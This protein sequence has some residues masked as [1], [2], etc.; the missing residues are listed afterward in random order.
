MKALVLSGGGCR[1]AFQVGVLKKMLKENPELDYDIYSGISVGALNTSMLASG[2]LKETLPALESI[3]TQDIKGNRSVW[4]HKMMKA[5]G[6]CL[7]SLV[8]SICMGFVSF[9]VGWPQWLTLVFGGASVAL[10]GVLAVFPFVK[11]LPN[12]KSFY[13]TTPLREIIK[14]RLNLENLKNSGKRLRIGAVSYNSGKYRSVNEKSDSIISWIMA[15][16]AFPIFFP[17]EDIDGEL[18]LDGGVTETAPLKDALEMGATDIDVILT[19]P[20]CVAEDDDDRGT[21]IDQMF[22]A[23]DLMSTEIM[24]N[25][26]IHDSS[27]HDKGIKIRIIAPK[28]HFS[29]NPLSF[30]PDKI[31]EMMEAE[32]ESIEDAHNH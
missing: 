26:V 9:I 29:V 32:F 23:I 22:R 6:M 2:P 4:K 21:V 5:I 20:L 8:T 14:K 3:W 28:K 19:G 11:F 25:D 17:M 30:K 1:G 24:A 27:L 15:S 12:N 31:R 7:V 10:F 16:S 18:W 13:D